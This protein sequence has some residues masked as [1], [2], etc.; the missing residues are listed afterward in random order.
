MGK[1]SP[2]SAKYTIFINLSADGIVERPDIIGAVFGQTEGLLGSELELRELQKSG[3]I[4]R[5]DVRLDIKEGKTNGQ[6]IIPSSLGRAETAIIAAAIETIQRV[7]PCTAKLSVDK[8]EDVRITKRDYVINRAKRILRIMN[9]GSPD[10]NELTEKVK[11]NLRAMEI[12]EYGPEKLPAGPGIEDVE[13]IIVVEG[14]A[15]VINLL[16]NGFRNIV[17]MNG[18]SVPKTV[19]DLIKRKESTVFVD[20]DRGGELI[21]REIKQY[22]N[23]DFVAK[24]PD[25]K[26]VEELTKKEIH[27]ALRNKVPVEQ[28]IHLINEEP[29]KNA[30]KQKTSSSFKK[31]PKTSLK[32]ETRTRT[33]SL[34]PEIKKLYSKLFDELMGTKG[35]YLLDADTNILGKV[36]VSELVNSIKEVDNIHSIIMD[37]QLNDILA[38]A[39][40]YKKVE[41]VLCT[42][43]ATKERKRV[44]VLT[45]ESLK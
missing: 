10:S 24:A 6:I 26:E 32:Q 25:G 15:D 4:G 11:S 3:R 43:D 18:T 40:G 36:P 13:D 39:M 8:V 12:T 45:P 7:G 38:K 20:G 2:V 14:R 28:E 22:A 42:K 5:I 35:A 23:I 31:D 29:S 19:I 30:E 34:N 33:F 1:I 37:S 41:L 16:K 9:E 44:K 17:A 21:I 27:Q